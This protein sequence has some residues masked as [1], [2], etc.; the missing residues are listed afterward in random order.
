MVK[1][2]LSAL[3][4]VLL[5][6]SCHRP[7]G[8]GITIPDEAIAPPLEN[9][10]RANAYSIAASCYLLSVGIEGGDVEVVRSL[11]WTKRDDVNLRTA[12][13]RYLIS[14]YALIKR[15]A[16]AP[17]A[18]AGSGEPYQTLS[19][20]G[21]QLDLLGLR[22]THWEIIGDRAVPDAFKRLD[23][24]IIFIRV[25]NVWKLDSDQLLE[26]QGHKLLARRLAY[27]A[28][29]IGQIAHNVSSGTYKSIQEL[30]AALSHN[31]QN[32]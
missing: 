9:V 25:N 28:D 19:R 10:E 16:E 15:A 20:H 6:V 21:I 32:K 3:L 5:A 12:E 27:E 29:A 26:S 30:D 1:T 31:I 7:S 11:L 14:S 17:L 4:C 22:S 24:P 18:G 13:A 8:V 23:S 2:Q